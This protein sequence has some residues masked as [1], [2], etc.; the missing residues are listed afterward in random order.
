[1]HTGVLIRQH[2][3]GDVELE[4]RPGVIVNFEADDVLQIRK[5]SETE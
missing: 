3:N 1:V 5:I 2:P 4:V